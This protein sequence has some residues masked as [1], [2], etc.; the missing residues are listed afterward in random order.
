MPK[1][2]NTFEGLNASFGT[3]QVLLV[4]FLP[5]LPVTSTV[6]KGAVAMVRSLN[7]PSLVVR[8]A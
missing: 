1:I 6:F 7:V 3:A 4:P 8:L 2:V 5:V